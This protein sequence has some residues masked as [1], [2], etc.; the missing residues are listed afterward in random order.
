MIM[1]RKIAF[2]LCIAFLLSSVCAYA[3]DEVTAKYDF[4]DNSIEI[5]GKIGDS[6]NIP[7]TAVVS[8]ISDKTSFSDGNLPVAAFLTTTKDGGTIS[9]KESFVDKLPGG[10]YYI[11]LFSVNGEADY[12]FLVFDPTSTETADVINK[13]NTESSSTA[14]SAYL[15][16]NIEKIGIRYSDV[17]AYIN[18]I[19]S[20]LIDYRI[21]NSLKYDLTKLV[22]TIKYVMLICDIKNSVSVDNAF[23]KYADSLSIT[24]D[25]YS[26]LDSGVKSE[27]EAVIKDSKY[28]ENTN[29][30]SFDELVLVAKARNAS[31]LWSSLKDILLD[32]SSSYGIE[33]GSR[34]DYQKI[35]STKRQEVFYNSL[36]LVKKATTVEEIADIYNE[37]TKDVLNSSSGSNK[38]PSSSSGGGGF[39][40]PA[41]SSVPVTPVHPESEKVLIEEKNTFVD[42]KDHF[43]KTEIDYLVKNSI[44]NGYADGSFKPDNSISRAEFATLVYKAFN[45]VKSDG[46]VTY[47]DVSMQDWYYEAI[48]ALSS[49]NIIKGDGSEF[50]PDDKITRQDAAVILGRILKFIN[51]DAETA[52]ENFNDAESVSEYAKESVVVLAGSGIIKGSDGMFRPLD[53]ITRGETAI[54]IYRTIMLAAEE[55]EK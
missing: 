18:T 10:V 26:S 31:G 34:S 55:V 2:L 27:I 45:V 8:Q 7:V 35:P 50:R 47:N 21:E 33:T 24:Y 40:A 44:I 23:S 4:N 52:E 29:Y 3:S 20:F 32:N 39:I 49:N 36:E 51:I 25:E 19:S 15:S 17:S 41:P 42:T 1:M 16:S 43:A 53:E 13:V 6:A 14:L 11:N 48:S 9:I 5:M 37:S 28:L 30:I 46:D 12:D 38:K 54:V 22:G